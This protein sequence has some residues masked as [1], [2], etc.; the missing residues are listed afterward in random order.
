MSDCVVRRRRFATLSTPAVSPEIPLHV[1]RNCLKNLKK[2]L[3][4]LRRQR[5]VV[6]IHRDG[7][8]SDQ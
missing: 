2:K 7:L 8:F 1:S 6:R 3:N 5:S 4:A